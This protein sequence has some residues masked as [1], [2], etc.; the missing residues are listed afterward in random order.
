MDSEF[1]NPPRNHLVERFRATTEPPAEYRPSPKGKMNFNH[2]NQRGQQEM[3]F[4]LRREPRQQQ[5]LHSDLETSTQTLK[6]LLSIQPFPSPSK[7]SAITNNHYPSATQH[8]RT[9]SAAQE[10]LRGTV[11]RPQRVVSSPGIPRIPHDLHSQES[12][13]EVLEETQTTK[14]EKE[15]RKVL[16]LT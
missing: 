2:S 4:S 5:P 11:P 13:T 14:M 1:E 3:Q 9:R 10:P 6:N 8:Q 7:S 16:N 15:L 12:Q